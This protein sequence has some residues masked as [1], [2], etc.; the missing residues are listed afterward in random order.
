MMVAVKD[1]K[2]IFTMISYSYVII[3]IDLS[4]LLSQGKEGC[5]SV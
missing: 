3:D 2:P 5:L 1:F 4:V